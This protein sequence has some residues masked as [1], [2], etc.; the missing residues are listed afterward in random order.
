MKYKAQLVLDNELKTI[1]FE[2]DGNAIQ[3]LWSHYGMDTYIATLDKLD[4]QIDK[5]EDNEEDEIVETP[6]EV[7]GDTGDIRDV[8]SI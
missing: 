7:Q 8:D 6:I 5:I 3:Y 2:T 4:I 1:E